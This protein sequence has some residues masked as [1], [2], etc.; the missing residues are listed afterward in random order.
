LDAPPGANPDTSVAPG[1]S[2]V[3]IFTFTEVKTYVNRG[4]PVLHEVKPEVVLQCSTDSQ[5]STNA[6]L[7][8]NSKASAKADL[9]SGGRAAKSQ[10]ASEAVHE[11]AQVLSTPTTYKQR[12]TASALDDESVSYDNLAVN[13]CKLSLTWRKT[14]PTSGVLISEGKSAL[15]FQKMLSLQVQDISLMLVWSEPQKL[16]G[17]VFAVDV[18]QLSKWDPIGF[19]YE[20]GSKAPRDQLVDAIKIAQEKCGGPS[21][22]VTYESASH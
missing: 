19:G 14:N 8:Q 22:E 16:G 1:Q 5:V 3:H 18:H 2:Y 15:D 9:T 20:S 6:K 13:G 11:V 17:Q 12:K 21:L 7:N 4:T 10:E